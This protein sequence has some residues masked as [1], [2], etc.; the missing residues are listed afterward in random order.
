MTA[1]FPPLPDGHVSRGSRLPRVCIA[2]WEIEGPSRNAGIGTAYTSLAD[3]LKQAGYDVTILFLL[4]CHPTDGNMIDWVDYYRT[5][6][7]MTLIPLPM[8]HEPRIHAAWASSVSYHTYA[9]LK[10]HQDDFDIIHFPECQGLGFYSLLAKRQGLAFGNTT[11]VISAHGPTFWVK[12]GSQDYIRN[13]GELEIDFMERTSISAADIVTSPSQYLLRWME[14]NG[15]ELPERTYVAPYVLPKGLLSEAPAPRPRKNEIREIVFFGRLEIRKGLKLFCDAIDELCADRA[16]RNFE[17]TFLG[18]ETQLYGRSSIGYISD[19]SK[20]W[21]VPWRIH[22]NK[23]QGAAI[24]YLRGAGRLAVI[25]SLSDNYPNTVLECVGAGVPLLASK[26]GGIPE[27]IDP[28]DVEKICFDPGPDVLAE[29]L[30]GALDQGAFSARPSASFT[31]TARMWTDFHA[32]LANLAKH[33]RPLQQDRR[34]SRNSIFP[35]VTVCFAYNVREKGA[36]ATLAS[37]KQQDYPHL[38]IILAECGSEDSSAANSSIGS[39]GFED[40]ELRRIL[41]RGREIGAARNAAVRE[42]RGGIPVL[43][44]RSHALAGAQ[45]DFGL[46]SGRATRRRRHPDLGGQFFPRILQRIVAKSHRAFAPS[47]PRR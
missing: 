45:R 43:R 29:R 27:I 11:F 6:K 47:V 20:A 16:T 15:W 7:G 46:R 33:E 21:T 17:V 24:E 41:R 25:S 9:W 12:E 36:A 34:G 28:A 42:S 1:T 22:S 10:E 5:E 13:L 23:Y 39:K 8:A 4:G 3:A 38:E 26:V 19:R 14:E 30:R 40:H 35:L 37:L 2:T 18:K 31:D 32:N 44:R